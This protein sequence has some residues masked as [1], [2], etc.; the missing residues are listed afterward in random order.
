MKGYYENFCYK[1]YKVVIFLR[2]DSVTQK[3]I[4]YLWRNAMVL[5][6]FFNTIANFVFEGSFITVVYVRYSDE[7]VKLFM[8][9]LSY[10]N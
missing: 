2:E 1:V 5:K 3:S 10:R 9:A 6:F 4:P 8:Q 7:I